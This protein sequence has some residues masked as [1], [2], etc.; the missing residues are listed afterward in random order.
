MNETAGRVADATGNWVDRLAPSPLRPYLRLARFD[1]PIGAWL[2]LMV[3]LVVGLVVS[4]L[5]AITQVNEA[6]LV[7]LP[8]LLALCATLVLMGPF[9][10]STLTDF[11]TLLMERV[12][13][14]GAP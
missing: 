1:R 9:M 12:V 13:Q 7:F 11:M 5:Q 4:L 2:L 8:K 10:A 6:S 14:A 3:A